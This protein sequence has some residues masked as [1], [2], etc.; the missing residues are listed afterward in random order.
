VD[1]EGRPWHTVVG[2]VGSVRRAS[3]T[4]P[5][6]E[7]LYVPV[8]DRE[9]DMFPTHMSLAIRTT[10]PP[11]ELTSVVRQIVRDIDPALAIAN[12]RTMER[13]V[14]DATA[15]TTFTMLLL[16]IAAAG[17]LFL[18]ALGVYGVVSHSVSR[19][20][21]E[22]GIRIALGART[23]DVAGMIARQ[24]S[25][26][27][28]TGITLGIL[29]ALGVSRLLG[30]LLFEVSPTDPPTIAAMSLLL[31]LVAIAACFFP[32]RRAARV[33]PAIALRSE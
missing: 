14:A 23:A 12:V 29:I 26:V 22:F 25:I 27:V 3:V 2:I 15:R 1:Y 33:D 21:H 7:V 32:A 28:L 9:M 20:T 10:L 8:L 30:G 4:G 18:G 17:A 6:D 5:A 24:G 11:L 19:R 16:S 31:V 13:I